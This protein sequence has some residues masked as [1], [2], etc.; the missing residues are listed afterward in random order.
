[1]QLAELKS[2]INETINEQLKANGS[3]QLAWI[4]N[5]LVL[6]CDF[7]EEEHDEQSMRMLAAREGFRNIVG[8]VNRERKGEEAAAD[9]DEQ[10]ILPGFDRLQQAYSIVR[11][12]EEWIVGIDKMSL[13]EL[14]AKRS[15]LVKMMKGIGEHVRE[16]D[17][18]IRQRWPDAA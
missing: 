4:V 13:S 5:R 7:P 6:E 18:Y 16:I 2:K 8:V 17:T 1:M 10:M 11:R 14:L 12:K 15:Q 9:A 3:V